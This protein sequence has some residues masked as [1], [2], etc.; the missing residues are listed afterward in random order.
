MFVPVT[1]KPYLKSNN[2]S[3]RQ[4]ARLRHFLLIKEIITQY[5]FP[6]KTGSQAYRLRLCRISIKGQF[7]LR[8]KFRFTHFQRRSLIRRTLQTSLCLFLANLI[9]T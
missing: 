7:H 1:T 6:A 3:V 8:F 4:Q 9:T 2:F 5:L